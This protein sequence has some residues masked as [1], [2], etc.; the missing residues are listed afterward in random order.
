MVTLQQNSKQNSNH[1]QFNIAWIFKV[2]PSLHTKELPTCSRQ[3][4]I[5]DHYFVTYIVY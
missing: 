3:E 2:I 5:S 4:V 1:L